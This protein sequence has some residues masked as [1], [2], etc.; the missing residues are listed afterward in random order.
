[1]KKIKVLSVRQPWAWVIVNG[2]KDVEN[3]NW[4]SDYRGELYIHASKKFDSGAVDFLRAIVSVV[5]GRD[6]PPIA[7]HYDKGGIV[8]KVNMVDCVTESKSRWFQGK[9]GFVF[10]DSE[11]MPFVPC[12]GQLGI[13]NMEL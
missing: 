9:Y 11:A 10:K 7:Q 3:R 12:R 6:L 4:K 5:F 2:F 1:M 8:G 13:F